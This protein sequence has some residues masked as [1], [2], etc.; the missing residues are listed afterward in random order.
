MN[1]SEN[2]VNVLDELSKG[3][4]MGKDAIQFVL[5]KVT[6]E[7]LKNE[8]ETQYQKY[9]EVFQ[10]IKQ[11]YPEYSYEE[12][13]QTNAMNKMMTWYGI[14]MKTMLD[15]TTTKIAELIMQGTNMGIIEG[16]R[17]L[18]HK[19]TDENVKRIVQKYVDMQEDAVEKLKS[20]L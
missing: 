4:C 10:E 12:P 6:D 15:S 2:E 17:L 5:D 11:I 1:N 18:N 14:E 19:D 16:R 20:F 13:H 7:S 3:A 9:D 8:L